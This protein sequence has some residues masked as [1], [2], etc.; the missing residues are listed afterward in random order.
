MCDE[1]V[2]QSKGVLEKIVLYSA[3]MKET[4]SQYDKTLKWFYNHFKSEIIHDYVLGAERA[5]NTKISVEN[6]ADEV[7][8]G[9][10]YSSVK[11]LLMR[12]IRKY[13]RLKHKM[14]S[15]S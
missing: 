11:Y 3:R 9:F 4:V 13:I 8:T 2:S 12:M 14:V 7:K 6:V 5:W 10:D 15:N 1:N